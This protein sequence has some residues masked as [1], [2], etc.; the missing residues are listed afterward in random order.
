[1]EK[2]QGNTSTGA[3]MRVVFGNEVVL[4]SLSAAST[5]GDIAWAVHGMSLQRR[6]GADAV[7]VILS[8][9]RTAK[10]AYP[11]R[12]YEFPNAA[13]TH[14]ASRISLADLDA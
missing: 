14:T 12:R 9:G 10:R 8:Q 2:A 11:A 4:V 5:F 13:L 3:S 1:M 6:R 7:C